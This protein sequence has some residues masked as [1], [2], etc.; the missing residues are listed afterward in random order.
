MTVLQ[1]NTKEVY[2]KRYVDR[3]SITCGRDKKIQSSLEKIPLDSFC[4]LVNEIKALAKL[5][6]SAI[7]NTKKIALERTYQ[8]ERIILRLGFIPNRHGED[9]TIHIL[10][11]K[12][13]QDYEQKQMDKIGDRALSLAK[14]L[15][16]TLKQMQSRFHSAK[17]SNLKELQ[18]IQRQVDGYLKLLNR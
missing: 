13:L 6:M 5:P 2:L 18:A 12:N 14:E 1:H 9:I 3:G 11:K 16:T 15:E 17:V 10:R 7:A 8:Q 4:S